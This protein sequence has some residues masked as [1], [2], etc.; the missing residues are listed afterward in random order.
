MAKRKQ[1]AEKTADRNNKKVRLEPQI[2]TGLVDMTSSGV[3]YVKVDGLEGDIFV[4]PHNGGHALDGDRVDVRVT[5]KKRGGQLEG[6]ITGVV[7]RNRR[8]YVG[9]L[10]VSDHAV[11]VK[12]DTRKIPVDIYI[13]REE[14]KEYINGHKVVVKIVDWPDGSKCPIGEVVEVLGAVGD[15][16]TEMHAILAEFDL[17]YRF[18]PQVEEAAEVIPGEITAEERARRRDFRA[19]T[20]FTIDPEDAKDFDDALSI[21]RIGEAGD[22]KSLWEIGVHI[23]DV[24]H[25]VTLGSIVDTEGENRATSVYLVDRTVPMLPEKGSLTTYARCART[26]RNYAFRPFSRSTTTSRFT[27]SGSAAR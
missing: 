25:Y 22:G 1:T 5:R 13:K 10:D 15:N 24:T 21:R 2:Y 11:F 8:N 23:A 14:G 20:T 16:D 27:K 6:E 3:I 7:E 17:P 19:V 9:I 18:E 26:R 12:P 4:D